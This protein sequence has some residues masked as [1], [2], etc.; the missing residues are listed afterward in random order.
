V[1]AS[2]ASDGPVRDPASNP[3]RRKK[4]ASSMQAGPPRYASGDLV[5]AQTG[6]SAE[7]SQ[8][9]WRHEESWRGGLVHD[10]CG[11]ARLPAAATSCPV[12]VG[13]GAGTRCPRGV[14]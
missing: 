8:E 10:L 4:T 1:I 7:R 2:H 13:T 9:T 12:Q 3:G 5:V 14:C 11:C 6:R